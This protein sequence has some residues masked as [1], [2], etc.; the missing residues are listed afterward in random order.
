MDHEFNE[1]RDTLA[2]EITREIVRM[3]VPIGY[4]LEDLLKSTYELADAVLSGRNV[5][6]P[7]ITKCTSVED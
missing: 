4:S 1:L 2:I 7:V 5:S 3:L 6:K